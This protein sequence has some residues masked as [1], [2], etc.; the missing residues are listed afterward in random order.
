MTKFEVITYDMLFVIL[1]LLL[2]IDYHYV[3]KVAGSHLSL[4]P[5]PIG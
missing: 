1:Y 2:S 5:P 4:P 3:H